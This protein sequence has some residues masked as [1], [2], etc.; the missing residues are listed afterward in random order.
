MLITY[1]F[2][3]DWSENTENF[4]EKLNFE[5]IEKFLEEIKTV[6]IKEDGLVYAVVNSENE[7]VF[8]MIDNTKKK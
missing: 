7:H 4:L 8:Y 1:L 6:K 5:S 2:R 3:K